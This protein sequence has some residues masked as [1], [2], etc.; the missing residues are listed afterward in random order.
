M[1][2]KTKGLHEL[3]VG[4]CAVV[5]EVR[6]EEQMRR[7]LQDLGLV[8]NT[9]VECIGKAPGGKLCAYLIR[10]AVIAIRTLDGEKVRV[11][12]MKGER[13]VYHGAD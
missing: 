7:R 4:D 5:H 9:V 8:E 1:I 11:L 10:G 6:N 13:I 3:N 12:P 2:Q